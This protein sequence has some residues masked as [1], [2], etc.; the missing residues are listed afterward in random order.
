MASG[1]DD[2]N[3]DDDDNENENDD[4]NDDDD[5]ENE[6]DNIDDDMGA[7]CA[8]PPHATASCLHNSKDHVTKHTSKMQAL[9]SVYKIVQSCCQEDYYAKVG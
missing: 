3:Y 2:D 4:D 6:N 7:Q 5:D 8:P 1:H 9:N